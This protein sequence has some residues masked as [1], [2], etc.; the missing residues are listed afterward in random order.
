MAA[1]S[2]TERAFAR[3]TPWV[4]WTPVAGSLAAVA[5]A[6]HFG[7]Q[8]IYAWLTLAGYLVT[9]I[10]VELGFHRH[11]AHQAFRAHPAL[12][13]ALGIAGSMAMQGPAI[14]WLAN[15]LRHHAHADS[16][17]DP[18]S[19]HLHGDGWSGRLRG[20]VHA[21]VGWVFDVDIAESYRYMPTACTK[22]PV[23]RWTNRWFAWISLA[24]I[25]LPG[26]FAAL[27]TR[28]PVVVVG[29][30]LWG[31][32]VRILL[33]NQAVFAVNSL[34]HTLGDRP[35]A[36]RDRSTNI[37]WL[38]LPTLGGSWHNNHHAAPASATTSRRRSE[39]DPGYWVIRA[40]GALG[41]TWDIRRKH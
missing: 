7:F 29:A 2:S 15:H 14:Y 41:L 36:R 34:C 9:M 35:A 4:V 17:G 18:H 12:R 27:V 22:D 1:R 10:G 37:A 5:W 25:A 19:P 13:V 8:A 24:G 31:G 30:C 33:V 28:A 11:F 32:F 39:V 6:W 20:L 3:L 38:A 23:V 21:H 40:W 16:P 26:I